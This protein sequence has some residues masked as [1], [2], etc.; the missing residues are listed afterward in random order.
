VQCLDF[1][2]VGGVL[3]EVCEVRYAISPGWRGTMQIVYAQKSRFMRLEIWFSCHSAQHDFDCPA[4]QNEASD[5]K[6]RSMALACGTTRYRGVEGWFSLLES[7]R[8]IRCKAHGSGI[9]VLRQGVAFS[10]T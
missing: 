3:M 9:G 8:R 4:W 10:G 1:G 2:G 7:P 5:G 6:S